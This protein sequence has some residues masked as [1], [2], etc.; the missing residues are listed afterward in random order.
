MTGHRPSRFAPTRD[1]RCLALAFLLLVLCACASAPVKKEEE[2]APRFWPTG[3]RWRE[4]TLNALRDP[5]TWVP[6]AGAA[7]VAAGGWDKKISEWAVENTPV[8]GSV[9]NAKTASDNLR[10]LSD[11][12]MLGTALA[13]PGR[14]HPWRSRIKRILVEEAGVFAASSVTNLLKQS[15][16][17]ERPDHSDNHSF[18]SGHSTRAF[19]YAG[20]SSRNLDSMDMPGGART[21]LKVL[22]EGMAAG[23]AWARVEGNRHYPT[24]VLAG[25]AIGNF[26]AL[27]IHDSFLG[28]E[29]NVSMSL[30]VDPWERSVQLRIL[31]P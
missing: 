8:F 3:E 13:V 25:A 20:M 16:P 19:A 4:A 21:S 31:L 28:R 30:Q 27:F 29:E 7:T 11:L 9:E 17:R 14:G 15:I 23:T 26:M 1:T 10:A 22:F 12:G 6:A 24:D 2:A 5:V 18:P